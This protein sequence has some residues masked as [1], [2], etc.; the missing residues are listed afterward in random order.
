MGGAL[1][2]YLVAFAGGLLTIVSPC[3]LPVL[4]FVFARAD[5]PFRRSGLPL[6]AS[7]GV[8]FAA[9]GALATVTGQ[10]IVRANQIG[11]TLAM[12]LFAVFGATLL[13]PALAD[14]LSRP[15]VRLG[16][17]AQG[18]RDQS[19][20]GSSLLLGVSTGL[21]WT[22]CAGPILGLILAAAAV[23]GGTRSV[24]LL[25]SFA[26]GAA[27]ALA[28]ALLAGQR[29]FQM[30]KRSLSAEA[31]IRRGLGVAVLAGVIGIALGWDTGVLARMSLTSGAGST[32][33]EQRLVDR[34]RPPE[35]PSMA[36]VSMKAAS[37]APTSTEL[38]VMT[39]QAPAMMM[40]A[41]GRG[42]ASAEGTMP[43][44]DG[45]VQWLNGPPQTRDGLRGK[46]VMIDFWTY[47]CINCLRAIPY[48]QAWADKYKDAGLVVIG[49]HSPEFAFERDA[50]NVAKAVK[51][52][53]ITYPVAVDSNRKIWNAFRNQIWPAHYFIDAGGRIRSHHFGEGNYDESE[54]TIQTLLA[55]RTT[56]PAP[57]D[58]VQVVGAGAQ[59][60]PDLRDVRSPETYIGY[61]RQE[62]YASPE[63]I[64]KDNDERYSA[65]ARPRLNQWGLAGWWTVRGEHAV[66]GSPPGKI[67]FRFHAR[68]LHL[69]LGPSRSGKPVRFRVLLDGAPP[70]EDGGVDVDKQGNGVVNE[71]R[72][73]QLIRQKGPVEDRTFQIEFLD[74]GVEAFAFTFG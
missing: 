52:L 70:L 63:E 20:I 42:T 6:L 49:V 35:A 44:L 50:G 56:G 2:L 3:I 7:M 21:L 37:A 33:L 31:W 26:A 1:I 13:F 59:A 12:V 66:L 18:R 60:S 23:E 15:F 34:V 55:E 71:H 48:V 62:H 51:E 65:P 29:V 32:N 28:L 67:V 11:R 54:R 10:W 45:A 9:V 5:Q 43:Q 14:F 41:Q 74:S 19:S 53:K 4:P 30:M 64:A 58:L 17:T 8:T 57:S 73:F 22:P 46:V 61:E 16:A 24:G 68:D 36:S 25:L 69:V 40:A 39:S 27:W 47:S 38:P 72:L